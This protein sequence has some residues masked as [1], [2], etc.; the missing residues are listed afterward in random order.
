MSR[1]LALAGAFNFLISAAKACLLPFL[2]LYLRHLGISPTETG[3]VMGTKH[4]IGLVWSPIAGLFSKHYDKRRV[5][6]NSCL[7]ASA[8]VSLVIPFIPPADVHK[9]DCNDNISLISPTQSSRDTRQTQA[10]FMTHANLKSANPTNAFVESLTG[11]QKEEHN[12]SLSSHGN[13]NGSIVTAIEVVRKKRSNVGLQN[14]LNQKP[15]LTD[16]TESSADF[17]TSLKIMDIQ[18]Q[19]F[20]L[21]LL[22]VSVLTATLAPLEWTADDG[23][24][25]YLDFADASDRYSNSKTWSLIGAAFG[26]G[27]AGVIV[28]Q[29]RCF[30]AAETP[31]SV[32]HFVCFAVIVLGTIPVASFLPFYLNRK[33]T[34]PNGLVKGLQLVRGSIRA[35]LCAITV[36][37][38]GMVISA[39]ENFLLWEMQDNG[40]NELHMGLSLAFGL[41]S[42]AA[43]PFFV[44]KILKIISPGRLLA[45]AAA[46]V[47]VQC[48]YFSFLWGPWAVLPAQIL[49]TLSFGGLWW[50]VQVQCDDIALP[51][52][53]RS[54]TRIYN[55]L[56]LDLGRALGSITGGLAVQKFGIAWMFRGAAVGLMVWCII[57]PLLQVKAPRQ[58]RINYS[59]LL[60]ADASEAS[61][62]ESEQERDWLDKAIQDDKCNNNSGRRTR[63]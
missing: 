27:G 32:V 54:I 14:N 39:V 61:E 15:V 2:T 31:R 7:V 45:L 58:R 26:V 47:A 16:S 46:I 37:L 1:A 10:S 62:S 19:L 59:R 18:H 60:A 29:L 36:L 9:L 25:E 63:H 57:L 21:I 38:V 20:F 44:V 42:Q 4:F 40:S 56:C 33:R 52:S 24:Y 8:I 6:I 5:V 50:A 55:V 22:I 11:T 49:N 51:G 17:L 3:L 43:F 12:L 48:F 30:I 23:L 13:Q 35:L 53:E 41:I 34:R 28:S